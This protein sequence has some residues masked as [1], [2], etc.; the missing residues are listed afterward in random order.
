MK[1]FF[2]ALACA[3]S[4]AAKL[5]Q[6]NAVIGHLQPVGIPGRIQQILKK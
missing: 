6:I 1:K 3:H 5:Q 4:N 2:L